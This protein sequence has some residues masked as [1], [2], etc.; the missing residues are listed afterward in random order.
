MEHVEEGST[1]RG[2]RCNSGSDNSE[3]EEEEGAQIQ[4]W[5]VPAEPKMTRVHWGVGERSRSMQVSVRDIDVVTGV[6]DTSEDALRSEWRVRAESKRI[7]VHR[8]VGQRSP[9][10]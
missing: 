6:E 2:R 10:M 5:K 3:E 7:H 4:E 9:S 8:V 1:E